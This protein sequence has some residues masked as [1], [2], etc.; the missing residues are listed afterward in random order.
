MTTK[1]LLTVL[2]ELRGADSRPEIVAAA[3]QAAAMHA[4]AAAIGEG[5]RDVERALHLVAEN[6]RSDHPLQGCTL[7]GIEAALADI[8]AALGD[9][10][11]D[12]D[13]LR[14]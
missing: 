2:A 10:G 14:R 8:A 9:R 1:E 11:N 12:D 4:I 7:G 6:V 13:R 3:L 5:L